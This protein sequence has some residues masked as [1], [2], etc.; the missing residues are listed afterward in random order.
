MGLESERPEEHRHI[1]PYSIVRTGVSPPAE[2]ACAISFLQS[3]A[4]TMS[5]RIESWSAKAL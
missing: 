4:I 1:L 2:A 3:I 5:G